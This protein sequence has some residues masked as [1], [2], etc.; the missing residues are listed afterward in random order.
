MDINYITLLF[1]AILMGMVYGIIGF[2]SDKLNTDGAFNYQKFGATIVYSII[3]G[4]AAVVSGVFNFDTIS[5]WQAIMSPLWVTY[6]GLYLAL[7]YMFSKIVVPV[8]T[9]FTSKTMIFPRS[10][11]VD[12]LRKMDPESRKFLVFDLPEQNKA[13]TLAAVDA[14]QDKGTYRYAIESGAWIFLVE[15]GELTGSKH[16]YFRGWFGTSII[17]WKPIT[18]E[19]LEAIRK[20]GKFPNYD[21]L[22]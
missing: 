16:Y 5:N 2:F 8:V 13:P 1:V 7:I 15:F 10:T 9:Q 20:S 6:S 4:I 14:A 11:S 3:I 17:S 18:V 21:D 22:Y 19:C 12:P